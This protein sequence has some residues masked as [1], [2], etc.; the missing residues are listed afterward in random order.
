M[1]RIPIVAFLLVIAWVMTPSARAEMPPARAEV[2][3]F[4]IV[5]EETH[6]PGTTH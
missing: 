4:V 5:S 6:S 3:E 2:L 1:D